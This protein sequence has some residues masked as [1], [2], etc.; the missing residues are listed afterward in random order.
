MVGN[1]ERE[2]DVR[3]GYEGE[4]YSTISSYYNCQVYQRTLALP[5]HGSI[6]TLRSHVKQILLVFFLCPYRPTSLLLS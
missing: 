3:R 4:Y 5:R 2:E 1:L 6:S